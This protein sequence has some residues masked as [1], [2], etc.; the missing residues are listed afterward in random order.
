MPSLDSQ[1]TKINL[2]IRKNKK[3]PLNLIV[4]YL[5]KNANEYAFIEH[6]RDISPK[7]AEVEGVHY[8][9]VF[10]AKYKKIRLSTRLN[11][12]V[13][14]FGFDNAFGIEI[15]PYRSLEASLQ[16]LIHKN[17]PEKTQ[18]SISEVITNFDEG[19]FKT[20]MN[21]EIDNVMS[22]DRLYASIVASDNIIDVI[23][24]IGIGNYRTWRNV[25]TDMWRGIKQ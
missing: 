22:F 3:I 23:R 10:N 7:T 2:V 20:L 11:G 14:F 16:Y 4:D 18:H 15:E 21:C 6:T 12:I 5:E 17:N 25:I 24:D 8:H 19:D 9:I 13:D 1:T